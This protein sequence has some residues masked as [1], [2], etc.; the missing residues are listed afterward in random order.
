MVVKIVALSE[1]T[2]AKCKSGHAHISRVTLDVPCHHVLGCV[3]IFGIVHWSHC[4]FWVERY[5][6]V[7]GALLAVDC[8]EQLLADRF[9][10]TRSRQ[11]LVPSY[12]GAPCQYQSFCH[13]ILPVFF[14]KV[15][16]GV[17]ITGVLIL[18]ADTLADTLSWY[19]VTF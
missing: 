18:Y 5:C 4:N 17:I 6:W 16:V 11:T 3:W 7:R 10:S 8:V 19:M 12:L 13:K 9:S 1:L 14:I 15:D 2:S